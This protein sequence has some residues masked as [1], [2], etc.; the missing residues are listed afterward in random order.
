MTVTIKDVARE[1]GVSPST[2]SRVLSGHPRISAE[3]V[4]KV[5]EIMESMG[6]HPNL[7]AKSLVSR[8]TNTICIILPKPAEELFTNLFFMELIRGIIS[9]ARSSGYDVLISSGADEKEEAEAALRLFNGRRIDG[10]ILLHS[11]KDDA[12]VDFLQRNNHPFVLIGRSDRY[13]NILSVDTDNVKAAY[14]AAAHLIGQGHKRIG[15][16]SGPPNLI[17]S[18]DRMKG[19]LQA[20]EEHGLEV[21]QEWIMEGEFLQDSG[22]L[23]M[24]FM[25]NLPNRPTALLVVDDMVSF[26]V[27]RGL[28]ELKL[29]VPQ[30]LALVS[31]N[32]IPL[33]ELSTPPISSIDIGIYHLGYA[34][35]QALIRSIQQPDKP[36]TDNKRLIIPH[37]LMIRES[38]LHTI[39][40]E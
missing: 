27:L 24:S 5:K 37:R 17:V 2:V 18:H 38:S 15:F 30:D 9:Q 29:R 33:T 8:T 20:L 23:A 3:T 13:E 16:I 12:V 28:Q 32:N 40:S 25:M 10:A 19:Y 22:Y 6:Y 7:M 1:A 31:F 36:E 21:R 4:R 39:Q 26:G 14:D 35:A 34:A 11:R